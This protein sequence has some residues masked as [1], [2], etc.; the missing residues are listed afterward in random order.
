MNAH[1]NW[2]WWQVKR[3]VWNIQSER[4][5]QAKNTTD[6]DY[7]RAFFANMRS[8]TVAGIIIII[9]DDERRSLGSIN[10]SGKKS[11]SPSYTYSQWT[12]SKQE[13][14]FCP[15]NNYIDHGR[16]LGSVRGG[17]T[18]RLGLGILFELDSGIKVRTN[19]KIYKQQLSSIND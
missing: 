3:V 14:V 19:M 2:K 16:G 11:R 1:N 9:D 5:S 17:P 4:R 18:Y 10:R 12:K 8:S 15:T 6:A 13:W 7:Y